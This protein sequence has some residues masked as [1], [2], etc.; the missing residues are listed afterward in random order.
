MQE[1]RVLTCSLAFRGSLDLEVVFQVD[2]WT[3]ATFFTH[4]LRDISTFTKE[5]HSL[6]YLVAAQSV[7]HP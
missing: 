4:H 5:L 1:D 7:V 2:A 6:G 3:S